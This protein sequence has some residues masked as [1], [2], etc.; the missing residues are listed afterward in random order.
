MGNEGWRGS[1]VIVAVWVILNGFLAG[2][3]R[4]VRSVGDLTVF[5][6][7]RTTWRRGR[8]GSAGFALSLGVGPHSFAFEFGR[9]RLVVWR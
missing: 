1:D 5:A 8:A 6:Y 9:A 4:A 2:R 3:V 7:T